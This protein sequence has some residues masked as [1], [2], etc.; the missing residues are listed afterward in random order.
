MWTKATE[1][2]AVKRLA[3]RLGANSYCGPALTELL[4]YME[5]QMRDD[6]PVDAVA[7]LRE[8]QRDK[9]ALDN[10]CCTMRA[11]LREASTEYLQRRAVIDSL[12]AE[13][14]SIKTACDHAR[15]RARAMAESLDKI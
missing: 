12:Y 3:K 11:Q 13:E 15:N 5:A 2:E 10:E 9:E 14:A 8:A 7:R 4:P 6:F 1:L